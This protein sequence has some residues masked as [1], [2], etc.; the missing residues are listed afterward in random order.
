MRNVGIETVDSDEA[1]RFTQGIADD[2]AVAAEVGP[3]DVADV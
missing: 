2:A 1:V 3:A